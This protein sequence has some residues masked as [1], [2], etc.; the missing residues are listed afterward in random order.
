MRVHNYFHYISRFQFLNWLV[1]AHLKF[2]LA[3]VVILSRKDTKSRRHNRSV[4]FL[5]YQGRELSPQNHVFIHLKNITLYYPALLYS[6]VSHYFTVSVVTF[7][8]LISLK[9]KNRMYCCRQRSSE[10]TIHQFAEQS[11]KRSIYITTLS[12]THFCH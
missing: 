2:L 5:H 1:T 11:M 12:I 10:L 6:N 8:L 3:F 7:F 9:I 4:C